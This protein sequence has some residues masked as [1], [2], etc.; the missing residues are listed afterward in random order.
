MKSRREDPQWAEGGSTRGR[1]NVA[2]DV[3][4]DLVFTRLC[5]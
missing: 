3:G 4:V 1:G 2:E 5:L